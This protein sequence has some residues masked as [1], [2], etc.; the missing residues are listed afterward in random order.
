L[1]STRGNLVDIGTSSPSSALNVVAQS[2]TP[3][4][5]GITL[6][7]SIGNRKWLTRFGTNTDLG[8][9]YDFYD[10]EAWANKL[11]LTYTGRLGIGT[12]SPN[13]SLDINNG[14]AVF[15]NSGT[16]IGGI[17]RASGLIGGTTSELAIT[18]SGAQGLLFGINNAEKARIDSS[19][20]LLV[21]TGSWSGSSSN[22]GGIE[23][24]SA[25]FVAGGQVTERLGRWRSEVNDNNGNCAAGIDFF[26][27][28]RGGGVQSGSEIRF[29]TGF[30]FQGGTFQ[31]MT[32]DQN[33]TITFNAYGAGTLSTNASGVISASDGRYKTKTR[34]VENGLEA[35]SAL[36]PT[37]YKWNE[38]SPFAS[39]YE[40]LGFV[41]QE[42][43]A[44]IPE[45]SPGEDEDGKYRNYHDRAIIAMLVKGMQEQQSIIIELK[46][47]VAALEAQ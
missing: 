44:V 25:N 46:A 31:R 16:Y 39:E 13:G 11:T 3:G 34:Q 27:M 23:I 26:R 9:Y 20:R 45:A 12:T 17:G 21:G 28:P 8:L 14:A 1:G 35:I 41:A 18:T 15:S 7:N 42:V 33:G 5:D 36:N 2:D 37:Y 40:E 19:G 47:R 4:G 6:G 29:F 32:I 43:A 24:L 22:I 38:D 30:T 10:G